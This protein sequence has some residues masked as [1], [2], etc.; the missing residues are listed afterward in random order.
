MV[1]YNVNVI[2]NPAGAVSGA[3][4]V[5]RSLTGLSDAGDNLNNKFKQIARSLAGAFT[6]RA[7]VE[8]VDTYTSLQNRLKVVTAN[9]QELRKVTQDLL[10]VSNRSRNSFGAVVQI[11]S[12]LAVSTKQLGVSSKD[13]IKFTET[14][15]QTIAISGASSYEAQGALIQFSQAMASGALRGDELRSVLEQLPELANIIGKRFG[16]TGAQLAKLGESGRISSIQIFA[17]LQ[18]AAAEIAERFKKTIATISSALTVLRNQILVAIGRFDEGAGGA[19]F[20]SKAIILV[21]NNINVVVQAVK[22][23]AVFIGPAL[24]LKAVNALTAALKKNPLIF[25]ATAI[26]TVLALFPD[27]QSEFNRLLERTSRLFGG[28]QGLNRSLGTIGSYIASTFV[29]IVK[30]LAKNI[31]LVEFAVT[32]LSIAITTKLVVALATR[33]APSITAVVIPAL[34][35]FTAA[36]SVSASTAIAAFIGK[37]PILKAGFLRIGAAAVAMSVDLVLAA[38]N[39]IS[40]KSAALGLGAGLG[41]VAAAFSLVTA[42]AIYQRQILADIREAW[43]GVEKDSLAASAGTRIR[44]AQQEIRSIEDA[45]SATGKRQGIEFEGTVNQL[46]RIAI[47]N[48]RINAATGESKKLTKLGSNGTGDLAGELARAKIPLPQQGLPASKDAFLKELAALN[49]IILVEKA[50]LDFGNEFAELEQKR[51][52]LASDGIVLTST[53]LHLLS[54][55]QQARKDAEAVNSTIAQLDANAALVE[56][57]RIL[58]L[59]LQ[60]R[61]DLANAIE[62]AMLSAKIAALETSTALEDGFTR[63]FLKLQQEAQNLAAVGEAVVTVFADRATEAL[64]TFLLTGK[65]NFREF[66]NSILEDITKILVR[67]L[68]VQAITAAL[69]GGGGGAAGAGAGAA[70]AGAAGA[71]LFS[72]GGGGARAAGG[73][74]QPDRS[75]LVGENG[76]ELF[77][78]RTTGS[79]APNQQPVAPAPVNVQVVNVDSPSAVPAAINKGG[80]DEAIINVLARNRDRVR[81]TIG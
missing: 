71:G 27:L 43:Q 7:L 12:R 20:L 26:S 58:N 68:I 11:Y 3:A 23:L 64:S 19:A 38:K 76:P 1:N 29:G 4:A 44:Q 73:T 54:Q 57:E 8:Q 61:P 22:N 56:Q 6:V 18:D 67:L 34:A 2:L 52:E 39:A 16:V 35:S 31:E 28:F 32:A 81:Q 50:R 66:A 10:D 45:I 59:V 48:G 15:A 42:S 30:L 75:Y 62:N 37:G 21:A 13:L 80:S 63:A 46:E 14:L 41:A 9:S 33:L 55:L 49:Q 5:K 25:L 40:L 53:Q 72:P 51:L 78:P 70:V 60:K 36:L 69:D 47:L 79:I 24:L 77:Q 17:A 74:V 65:F